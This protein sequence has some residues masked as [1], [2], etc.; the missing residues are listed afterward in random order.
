MTVSEIG[1]F[2]AS[3]FADGFITSYTQSIDRYGISMGQKIKTLSKGQ[4]A[5]VALSLS[6]AHDPD[7]L[8]LDEPTSGLDPMV[9]REFLES[10]IERA[11]SGRTVFLS[12]HQISEVERVADTIAILHRG[13]LRCC[14]PINELKSSMSQITISLDD[15]LCQVPTLPSPARTVLESTEG[16]QHQIV[17]R[18]FEPEMIAGLED[19]SGV[20]AVSHRAMSLEEIFIAYTRR[21]D[22]DGS[23]DDPLPDDALSE[24]ARGG[25]VDANS[26]ADAPL[27]PSGEES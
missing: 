8:I 22:I 15:P 1:W 27:L 17:A 11:A 13:K 4:R 18:G 2:T 5:K 14:L 3:F 26:A 12:S 19:H 16:R 9:R 23:V 21:D 25:L 6:L 24:S 10:M 20:L 7:L